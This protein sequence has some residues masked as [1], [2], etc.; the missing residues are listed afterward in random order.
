MGLSIRQLIRLT[1]VGRRDRSE[2][3]KLTA[4]KVKRNAD[5]MPM[6]MAK[7]RTYANPKTG[8]PVPKTEGHTYISAFEVYGKHVLCS[9]SCD[10]FMYRFEYALWKHGAARLE[11]SN[12]EPPTST[13]PSKL[14]CLCKHLYLLAKTLVARGLA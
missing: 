14:P 6:V 10:D 1:D 12:G 5:G 7:T 11:Y 8:A 3:V 9:C 13:N 2:V 4:M